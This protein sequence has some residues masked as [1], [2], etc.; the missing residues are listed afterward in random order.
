MAISK[1]SRKYVI[2]VT[3]SHNPIWIE[4]RQVFTKD[5]RSINQYESISIN[6]NQYQD[7]TSV[8]GLTGK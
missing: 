8:P 1:G 5:N 2:L 3:L 7:L 6:I 4:Q